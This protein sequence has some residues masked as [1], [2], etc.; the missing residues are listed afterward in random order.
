MNFE[1]L[2]KMT[3]EAEKEKLV[4]EKEYQRNLQ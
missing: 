3:I 4:E 1:E 2:E